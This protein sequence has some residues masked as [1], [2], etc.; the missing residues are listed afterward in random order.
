MDI[1]GLSR[2]LFDQLGQTANQIKTKANEKVDMAE[3]LEPDRASA[4]ALSARLQ[5]LA[6]QF[7]VRALPISELI[8]LQDAL[9][10]QGFIGESQVRA[11]GLLPQL[12]FHHYEA[13]PMDV[14]QALQQHLDRLRDKPAVLADHHE[15]RHMLNLVRNLASARGQT[16][17]AA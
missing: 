16:E 13:G 2:R 17:T 9:K 14:E 7:D 1:M 11:Q 15:G 8:P 6:D 4:S 3:T 12:A 5:T 10:Q